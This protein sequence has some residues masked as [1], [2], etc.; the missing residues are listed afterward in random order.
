MRSIIDYITIK[1]NSAIRTFDVKVWRGAEYGSDHFLVK[2]IMDIKYHN[3][4][5]RQEDQNL[6]S[7]IPK[8]CNLDSL[9]DE[10]TSFLYKL[11]LAQKFRE[12]T[13]GTA[14]EIYET[15]K[16]KLHEVA[17]EALKKKREDRGVFGGWKKSRN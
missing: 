10:S 11:R 17:M 4:R 15:L 3:E 8:P 2:S 9:R 14:Q 6:N 13:T 5:V 7:E 1:Q 12:E 16:E